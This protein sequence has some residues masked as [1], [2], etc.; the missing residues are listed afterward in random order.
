MIAMGAAGSSVNLRE[1]VLVVSAAGA[2][3]SLGVRE[4]GDSS[5]GACELFRPAVVL[6]DVPI[7]EELTASL[8]SVPLN[9]K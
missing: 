3:Q 8:E 6:S 9:W 1:T 7:D 4:F 2:H 5:L